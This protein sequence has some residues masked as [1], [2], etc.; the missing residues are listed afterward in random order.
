MSTQFDFIEEFEVE[1]VRSWVK[2]QDEDIQMEAALEVAR[3][4]IMDI[5][6]P[7]FS[8]R[9][10]HAESTRDEI[11][12]SLHTTSL[13]H[14]LELFQVDSDRFANAMAFKVRKLGTTRPDNFWHECGVG[15]PPKKGGKRNER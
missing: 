2:S 1:K 13:S 3:L 12:S 15:R 7:L 6:D 8:L 5:A 10:T 14:A 11:L 4:R 9:Y